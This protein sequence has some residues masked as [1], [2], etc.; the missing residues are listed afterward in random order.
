MLTL[1]LPKHYWYGI[2]AATP[3]MSLAMLIAIS[4]FVGIFQATLFMSLPTIVLHAVVLRTLRRNRSNP[5]KVKM[6]YCGYAAGAICG[7]V[8]IATP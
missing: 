7:I 4:E 8:Q 1:F 2:L 5:D 6:I 3:P